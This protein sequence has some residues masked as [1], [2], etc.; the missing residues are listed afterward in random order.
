M[1]ATAG[2]VVVR[3]DVEVVRWMGEQGRFLL[4]AE[5]TAG[6]FSLMDIT[7]PPGGGPPLHI[8][9]ETDETFVILEGR[10]RITVADDVVEAAA[11]TVVYGPR[12]LAHD[13]RN[14]ADGPSR[15]LVVATPGGVERFFEDLSVLLSSGRRPEWEEMVELATRHHTRG[16]RPQGPMPG[17]DAPA[18]PPGAGVPAGAPGS[19]GPG[20]RVRAD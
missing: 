7:T 16:F 14:V 1:T 6:L 15:M 9:D 4:R 8:H 12:G 20:A 11:G 18:G 5:D 3:D 10:Y 2:K 13:F 17:L 19:A